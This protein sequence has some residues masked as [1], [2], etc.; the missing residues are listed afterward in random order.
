MESYINS[1]GKNDHPDHV[2]VNTTQKTMIDNYMIWKRRLVLN[3]HSH[4]IDG[5][6]TNLLNSYFSED[7][8]ESIIKVGDKRKK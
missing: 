1:I 3:G 2:L 6:R 5:I 8:I 4:L 7:K